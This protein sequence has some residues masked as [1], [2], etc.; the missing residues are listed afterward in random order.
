MLNEKVNN[1]VN[2]TIAVVAEKYEKI[3]AEKDKHIF[4]LECRLNINK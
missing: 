2:K 3:F 1:A 4:E